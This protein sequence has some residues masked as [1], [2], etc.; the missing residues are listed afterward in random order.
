M[1]VVKAM[2]ELSPKVAIATAIANSKLSSL[3]ICRDLSRHYRVSIFI[4]GRN[5]KFW[6]VTFNNNEY[7]SI[8]FM[9]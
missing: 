9:S 2:A 5:P 3:I 4:I 7:Q 6:I 8:T 1:T